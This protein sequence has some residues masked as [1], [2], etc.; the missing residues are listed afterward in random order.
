MKK[1][2]L[3]AMMVVGLAGAANAQSIGD[4]K[5]FVTGSVGR[6]TSEHDERMSYGAAFGREVLPF[7]RAE[8]AYDYIDENTKKG[9][10]HGQTL[11]ANAIGQYKIPG[12][13]IVPYVL[14]GTGYG[15][16]SFGD[17]AVYNV[18]AGARF[19]VTKVVDLDVR[20]KR[21]GNYDN[22]KTDDVVTAGVSV[23]F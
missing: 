11:V 19:E 3:A 6:L 18:G 10:G 1:F 16:Q 2:I 22:S 23:K 21:I 15:W 13:P 7:L 4:G 14:V 17:R 12:T 8:V 5:T 9:L 20:Y